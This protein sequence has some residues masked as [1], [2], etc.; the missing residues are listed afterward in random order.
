MRNGVRPQPE[1]KAAL[2]I[3]GKCSQRRPFE[4]RLPQLAAARAPNVHIET[5]SDLQ[6]YLVPPRIFAW[7]KGQKI[8]MLGLR[9]NNYTD[10]IFAILGNIA[11]PRAPQSRQNR[12]CRPSHG[13]C[14]TPTGP[15]DHPQ[16]QTGPA[17]AIGG[18]PD[19][20]PYNPMS[21]LKLPGYAVCGMKG[22]RPEF[23]SRGYAR[24]GLG[25]PGG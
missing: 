14:A 22:R 13:A 1:R 10:R 19:F 5:C 21:Y 12:A 24:P 17:K 23:V 7:S 3:C 4:P 15:T 8:S 18:H 20:A 6:K 9:D 16:A 2:A 11:P 25:R